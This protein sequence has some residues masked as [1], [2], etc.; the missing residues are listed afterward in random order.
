MNQGEDAMLSMRTRLSALLTLLTLGAAGPA[1]ANYY[2]Y[3]DQSCYEQCRI[4]RRGQRVCETVC[5][6]V[7]V[8]EQTDDADPDVDDGFFDD[9]TDCQE[10]E[11]DVLRLQCYSQAGRVY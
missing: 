2:C 10:I 3:D 6:P 1:F 11:N 8:C 9:V 5:V 7:R 4:N